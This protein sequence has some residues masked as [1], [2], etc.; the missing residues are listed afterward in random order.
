MDDFYK[1]YSITA[2]ARAKIDFINKLNENCVFIG[3]T[4]KLKNNNGKG[5]GTDPVLFEKVW[6]LDGTGNTIQKIHEMGR[7]R[8]QNPGIGQFR[9]RIL[10]PLN[11][12]I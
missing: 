1:S 9:D 4:P 7:E 2:E 8:L 5:G 3:K 10:V 6:D 11:A 12:L